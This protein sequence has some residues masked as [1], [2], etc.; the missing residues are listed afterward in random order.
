MF[1]KNPEP[2]PPAPPESRPLYLW[3]KGEL[4]TIGSVSV[5]MTAKGPTVVLQSFDRELGIFRADFEK[6]LKQKR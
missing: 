3:V 6:A 2:P 4:H 5:Q 1:W